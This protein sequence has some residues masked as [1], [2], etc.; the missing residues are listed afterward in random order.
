MDAKDD[1]ESVAPSSDSTTAGTP[2]HTTEQDTSPLNE[3]SSRRSS[4]IGR[5]PAPGRI[6]MIR[7]LAQGKTLSLKGGH[8]SLETYDPHAGCYW[9]CVE[10]LGWL[11]FSETVSGKYLGRNGKFAFHAEAKFHL[12]W[13]WFVVTGHESG[14]GYC[15]QSRFWDVLRWVGV[16]GNGRTLV[17]VKSSAEAA[18]WEFVEA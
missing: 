12:P 10:N 5:A 8:L 4:S 3:V 6:Y 16:G 14:G 11:G 15:L 17:E 2:T 18:V 1:N 7:H 9:N 13:E